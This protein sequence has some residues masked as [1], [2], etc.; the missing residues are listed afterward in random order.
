LMHDIG[1]LSLVDPVAAGA[2]EQL[3]PALQQRIAL[4]GG[5]V[6]RQTGVPAEIA[7]VVEQQANPFRE[8]TLTAR[9]VRAVNAYEDL[10]A[11][12]AAVEGSLRAL[13]R[14]RLGGAHDYDPRVVEALSRVVSRGP[15]A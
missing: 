5:A 4:L 12:K 1:Q 2:T 15:A 14:L 10:V 6:V 3:D 13:E 9:I 7:V 11:G 8:Q